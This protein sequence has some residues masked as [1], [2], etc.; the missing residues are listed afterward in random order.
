M[1]V[2]DSAD[3]SALLEIERIKKLKHLYT[4]YLD[5]HCWD[6]YRRLFTDD[7]L[8][9][10]DVTKSM[11][12]ADE[13]VA[14]IKGRLNEVR[15]SHA[16]IPLIIELEDATTARGLWRYGDWG[17]YE[18]KYVKVD[19]EWR[20]AHLRLTYIRWPDGREDDFDRVERNLKE[21]AARWPYAP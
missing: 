8:L 1:S 7:V 16:G 21:L 5:A 12:G 13:W 18:D 17:F 14:Y 4:V 6:E 9:D 10:G 2:A 20:I 11:Q 15:M 3:V 19:G